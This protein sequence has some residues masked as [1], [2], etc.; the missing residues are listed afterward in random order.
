MEITNHGKPL[1][2]ELFVSAL[3]RSEMPVHVLP[4]RKEQVK[5]EEAFSKPKSVFRPF[6][7]DTEKVINATIEQD[8]S[9]WKVPNFVKDP[10]D[11]EK[12]ENLIRTHFRLIKNM[13][14]SMQ[15]GEC[16]PSI[17]LLEFTTWCKTSGIQD[18]TLGVSTIDRM[19]IAVNSGDGAGMNT[20]ERGELLEIIV[21]IAYAKYKETGRA[22]NYSESVA[23]LLSALLRDHKPVPW[24]EFRDQLLWKNDINRFYR[25][26]APVMK[27]LH[28]YLFGRFGVDGYAATLELVGKTLD[29]VEKDVVVCFG[30]S[31]MT[32]IDEEEDGDEYLNLKYVEMLEFLAR[33]AHFKYPDS[34]DN[35]EPLPLVDKLTMVVDQ[36]LAAIG[37]KR[38]KQVIVEES[39][40]SDETTKM[41]DRPARRDKSQLLAQIF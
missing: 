34:D 3:R 40:S 11:L 29:I 38:V 5:Q 33:V 1:L 23:M 30:M 36:I 9:E 18:D 13:Y 20:L 8:F 27:K 7:E 22:K 41:E 14:T 35:E 32:I 24:Q 39:V 25:T 15:V 2:K 31:K 37:L 26:Q 6:K 12:V 4:P 16:Y 17:G 10:E 19:W 21:R 28:T